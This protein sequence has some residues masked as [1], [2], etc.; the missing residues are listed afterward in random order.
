VTIQLTAEEARVIGC[1]MEKSV[2]TP[3]QYPLTLNALTNACNQKS[4]RDPVMALEPGRVQQTVRQL[5]A[6]HLM[7]AAD[8]FKSRVEKYDQRFCNTPFADLQFS[9]EEFAV[10]CVLLLRGP[11][12][13]GEL[14][15]RANRLF[16][17]ADNQAVMATLTGLL[18]REEGPLVVRLPRMP[19]RQDHQY[20]HLFCGEVTSVAEASAAEDAAARASTGTSTLTSA[21]R[22]AMSGVDRLDVLE[23]RIVEL[24]TQLRELKQR[25][26]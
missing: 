9:S 16:A 6:K 4:S 10:L 23:A 18:E 11:Q 21:P 13:P 19:G 12:T 7:Q 15:T 25:L 14:R 2:T 22:T 1:L 5:E 3:E 26:D 24:E 20:M 17:F 8:N